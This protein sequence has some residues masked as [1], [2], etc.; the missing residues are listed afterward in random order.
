M[1]STKNGRRN[2][3]HIHVAERALG[4]PLPPGAVVHHV[5][6]D[7]ANNAPTN[8]VICPDQ[9]YHHLLHQRMRAMDACGNPNWRRCELCG[10]WDDPANMLTWARGQTKHAACVR[11][12][13]R[14]Y[15]ARQRARK[16]QRA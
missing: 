3:E 8:L 4:R 13:F 1:R 9:A 5:D 10:Q 7:K 6:E 16:E 14:N 12:Y 11:Q 2:L 15:R